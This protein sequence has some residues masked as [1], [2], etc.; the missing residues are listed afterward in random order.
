MNSMELSAIALQGLEQAQVQ[1]EHAAAQV[2][3]STATSDG[4]P[5]DTVDLSQ[6]MVLLLSARNQFE[7]N[8]AVL[9]TA[10]EMQR[11]VFDVLA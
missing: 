4:T 1:F 10:D 6:A 5:V 9:K 8:I 11:Q 2:T 7:A 3:A